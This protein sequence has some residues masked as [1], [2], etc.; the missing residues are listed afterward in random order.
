MPRN[1]RHH[2]KRREHASPKR[3]VDAAEEPL[4][5]LETLMD[6]TS[7]D[8]AE[9]KYLH[10]IA[11]P[12]TAEPVGVPLALGGIPPTSV[13]VR[14]TVAQTMTCG[15]SGSLAI[16]LYACRSPTYDY[17]LN[18]APVNADYNNMSI[19]ANLC[20]KIIR[21]LTINPPPMTFEPAVIATGHPAPLQPLPSLGDSKSVGPALQLSVSDLGLSY[22]RADARLVAQEVEIYPAGNIGQ[23]AGVMYSVV[24][25]DSS[26]VALNGQNASG[27]FQLQ[28]T[29][30]T[31]F[32]V[33]NWPSDQVVR[34][35]RVPQ[36]KEDLNF[37][38]VDFS[39]F[40][41]AAPAGVFNAAGPIWAALFIQ[42]T[43]SGMPVRVESTLVY[44]YKASSYAFATVNN[45]S[46]VSSMDPAGLHN[47][48][49]NL[50]R[51]AISRGLKHLM[52]SGA[53]A[54]TLVSQ[55]GP[56][57]ATGFMS[58]LSKLGGELGTLA[59]E[60]LPGLLGMGMSALS[61][62]AIPPQVGT[63][64]ANEIVHLGDQVAGIPSPKTHGF[65]P[66]P[67]LPVYQIGNRPVTER[68]LDDG[69]RR[70]G[71]TV[72]PSSES[73]QHDEDYNTNAPAAFAVVSK[74]TNSTS[75]D[76]IFPE[77]GG[78]EAVTSETGAKLYPDGSGGYFVH[79]NK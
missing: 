50:N 32:P 40:P 74:K 42:G 63:G 49:R 12:A 27:A 33:A 56:K 28:N 38:P 18:G 17:P 37:M 9:A 79:I 52:S 76:S 34:F 55:K 53:V 44:E 10:L 64:I 60:V 35:V 20:P 57:H 46:A 11:E 62:G 5:R 31:S 13:K 23:S 75:P 77:L 24:P 67:N 71:V 59:K 15:P 21:D 7:R 69:T 1:K 78:E 65:V 30:R 61:E 70:A 8:I 2:A 4:R 68:E 26:S 29:T 54:E 3:E 16:A 66:N 22:A 72:P 39:D 36:N 73:D 19:D 25:N 41:V 51:G 45:Q 43:Y 48:Q 14:V 6:P 47:M 58:F